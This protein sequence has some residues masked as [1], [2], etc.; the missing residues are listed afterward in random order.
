MPVHGH[1]PERLA[2]RIRAEVA[3]IISGEL[4]DPRIG[5][6]TVTGVDLSPDL[7]LARV[8][9]SVLGS[10]EEQQRSLQGLVSATGYV[11]HE[12]GVRLGLRRTPELAFVLDHTAE[13]DEKLETLLEKVK[14]ES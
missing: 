9:V 12:L 14:T 6:A 2:D 11:R 5:F 7:H 10:A 4:K 13:V 3:E 1:R 8:S